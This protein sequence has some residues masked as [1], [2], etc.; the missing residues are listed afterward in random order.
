MN[1]CR[2]RKDV[3]KIKRDKS[4][5]S[6]GDLISSLI[7][8]CIQV[9]FFLI[10][11]KNEKGQNKTVL[12]QYDTSGVESSPRPCNCR[13]FCRCTGTCEYYLYTQS[14]GRRDN[15]GNGWTWSIFVSLFLLCSFSSWW[16]TRVE[17]RYPGALI[18]TLSTSLTHPFKQR[19]NVKQIFLSHSFYREWWKQHKRHHHIRPN[20]RV[21]WCI[22]F[23]RGHFIRC[24]LWYRGLWKP[25]PISKF[26]SVEGAVHEDIQA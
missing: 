23:I 14:K 1:V 7:D 25:S 5:S 11:T 21:Q 10:P 12:L 15:A 3:Q 22:H 2:G 26:I 17:I 16:K 13:H 9:P 18:T 8:W 19:S 24:S 20:L 4:I 6:S